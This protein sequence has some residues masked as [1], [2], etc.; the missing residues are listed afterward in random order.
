MFRTFTWIQPNQ[1]G[2]TSSIG[3]NDVGVI[4]F[5][6]NQYV[7][8]TIR[9]QGVIALVTKKNVIACRTPNHVIKHRPHNKV[10]PFSC[11]PSEVPLDQIR[12]FE[13]LIVVLEPYFSNSSSNLRTGGSINRSDQNFTL[14]ATFNH[15]VVKRNAA[16]KLKQIG[17]PGSWDRAVDSINTV[18]CSDQHRVPGAVQAYVVVALASGYQ[19]VVVLCLQIVRIRAPGQSPSFLRGSAI[20]PVLQV[21]ANKFQEIKCL[22]LDLKPFDGAASQAVLNCNFGARSVVSY[23][24]IFSATT[25]GMI[26]LN[27]R[28]RR[29]FYAQ[30]IDAL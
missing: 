22:S 8:A 28:K 23:G 7:V 19:C 27:I 1:Q 4:A 17:F 12:Q 20:N 25:P 11:T 16:A 24:Q 13:Q 30:G 9:N 26:E 3:R 6:A 10:I 5:S 15:Y 14:G 2:H 21:G 18:P 29:A